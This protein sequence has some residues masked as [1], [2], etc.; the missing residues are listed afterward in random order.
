MPRSRCFLPDLARLPQRRIPPR[1][2]RARS[3][4]SAETAGAFAPAYAEKHHNWCDRERG[5]ERHWRGDRDWDRGVYVGSS[6]GYYGYA[7]PPVVYPEPGFSINI[8]LDIR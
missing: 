1:L 4:L 3:R 6:Y 5:H 8:P 7:P 2:H